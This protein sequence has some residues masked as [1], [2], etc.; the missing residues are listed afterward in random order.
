LPRHNARARPL[1]ESLR[2]WFEAT[3]PKLSRKSDTTAAIRYAL[4]L[5]DALMRYCDDGHIEIDN[6]AAER[7]LRAVAL[8]RKNYLFAG[9]DAGG[10]RAAAI[11]SLIGSAKLNGLDPEAYLREVLS[12][13][14]EHPIT[15]IEELL[16][17]NIAASLTAAS[18]TAA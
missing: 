15:R 3:I 18:Q 11:Y 2:E 4:S 7:A 17:W 8:G 1:L 14:A 16:P 5:W 9:S 12:R 13:I 10:E 6:N